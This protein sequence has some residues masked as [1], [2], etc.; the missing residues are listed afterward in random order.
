MRTR[1][2][3]ALA[4]VALVAAPAAAQ[5]ASSLAAEIS[6]LRGQIAFLESQLRQR[7]Q[8]LDGIRKDVRSLADE[9]GE[10]KDRA[11]SPVSGPFLAG[12]PPSSD[13]VGVAKVAVFAPRI[14]VDSSRR[15]DLVTIKVK[16]IEAAGA[17][18]LEE[19]QLG[20]DQVGVDVPIDQSGALYVVDWSTSEGVSYSLLLKDGASGQTAATVQVK[21]L[22]NEGRFI[23]VGYRVD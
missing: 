8:V 4:S 11:S 22:Q 3:A 23:L 14:E 19:T 20:T 7:E 13:S 16:R 15:H 21:P 6:H 1:R 2:L 9:I 18:A 17:K 12:P 10:I 5:D